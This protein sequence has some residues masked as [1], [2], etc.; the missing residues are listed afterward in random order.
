MFYQNV[1]IKI[2][3]AKNKKKT[4]LSKFYLSL[5]FKLS[6]VRVNQQS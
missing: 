4:I 1:I 5:H 3:N 6:S 2:E